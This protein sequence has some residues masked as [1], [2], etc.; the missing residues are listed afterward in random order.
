[1]YYMCNENNELFSG[2]FFI[3]RGRA[4]IRYGRVYKA[5]RGNV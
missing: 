3:I 1:M 4:F 5:L 2:I